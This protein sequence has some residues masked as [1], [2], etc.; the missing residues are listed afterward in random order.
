MAVEE[1]EPALSARV[2]RPEP[3]PDPKPQRSPEA[4][5]RDAFAIGFA[6]GERAGLEAGAQRTD[7]MLR[8]LAATIDEL[9]SLRRTL[10]TQSEREMVELAVAI[11]RR[12]VQREVTIDRELVVTIARVAL[13]R[14]AGTTTATIRLNPQDAAAVR[15]ANGHEWSGVRVSVVP[16]ES[17]SRGGC[18]V[19][20]E[21]GFIDATLDAQLDQIATALLGDSDPASS[22]T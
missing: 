8:R 21:V 19:E 16:D 9:T 3:P 11:A 7:A 4:I 22:I 6:Q 2:G 1:I 12:I 10:L 18:K 20:S 14:L 5:E 17:I 15:A 13:E